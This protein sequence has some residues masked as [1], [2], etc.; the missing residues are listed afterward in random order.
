M[1]T[2]ALNMNISKIS[3]LTILFL[4]TCP[5][6]FAASPE[7]GPQGLM[8]EFLR[9][10]SQ[11]TV[12]DPRPSFSW[13]AGNSAADIQTCYQ[14]LVSSSRIVLEAGKGDVWNSGK[15]KSDKS[16]GIKMTGQY[17]ISNTPYYWR[18][19]TWGKHFPAGRMSAIQEF[20]TGLFNNGHQTSVMPLLKGIIQPLI[21]LK[22]N[23]RGN[24]YS[25]FGKAAFGSL[26][27]QVESINSDSVIVHLGEKLAAP[28]LIN[29]LPGGTI[30]YRQIVLQVE[31]GIKWYSVSIPHI[32]RNS[33]Y[34]AIVMP[35]GIGE[36][37]PFRYCEI[38][39]R[40]PSTICKSVEQIAV[41][42]FWD[43]KESS[44]SCSDTILNRVWDLCKYSIKATSFCGVYVDGDRERIPYEADAYINQL[45]HYC[46]DR[47]YSMARYSHEYLMVN[48]TWPTEWI[49]HSVI[50]AYADYLYTG[51][52]ES[53][54]YFYKDLKNKTLLSL[55]RD[56]GLIS[57]QT[58]LLNQNVLNEI[59]I[60]SP[61]RDI[62]D[63]PLTERDG[64]E[65]PKIN[66]VINAFHYESLRLMALIAKA[67]GNS[68]DALLFLQRSEDLKRTINQKLFDQINRKYVDGEGSSHSSIHANIFPM[69]FG[70]VP[71]SS[72][73]DVA[74]FIIEKGMACS[75]YAAQFLLEAL[76][77]A[78]EDQAALDLMRATNDRSWWNMI[79]SGSTITLEAWDAKFKPNLDWNHAWGAVP[80]NMITRGLWGIVP[81]TPGFEVAQ[82]KPQAGGLTSS[83]II[84][85]TIRGSIRCDFKTDNST[86]FDLRISVP[87]NMKTFVYV[88]VRGIINPVLFIDGKLANAKKTGK[89]F[90]TETGGGQF[91]FSVRSRVK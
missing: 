47:E 31:K 28:G 75:V 76:Y 17:L 30:R 42:Y 6:A 36:V 89:F 38:E 1:K 61:I 74:K 65:M 46:T 19:K 88:P 12:N 82:I 78:G 73:S 51:D 21:T 11:G 27:V 44:F 70:L 80:A 91:N 3:R 90:V 39:T 20:R 8:V 4:L 49:M 7:P 59:H 86:Q 26:R 29:R 10:P 55:A 34:P 84:T 41:N 18:V 32:E 67:L 15:I 23:S 62:V 57:T 48:P 13:I 69:A 22:T 63:W 68:G 71:D 50:M 43:E 54:A 87:S 58:G 40:S 35:E 14:V 64:N 83:E 66:T 60:K 56:D 72:V 52:T 25:D 53:L 85:P 2:Y 16:A 24:Y 37:T 81:L 9:G 45:G 77:R 33:R 5:Y 79:K